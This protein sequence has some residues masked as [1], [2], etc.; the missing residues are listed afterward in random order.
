[1]LYASDSDGG[2]AEIALQQPSKKHKRNDLQD[3]LQRQCTCKARVCFQQ[4][5]LE[6]AEV[7]NARDKFNELE[8]ASKNNFLRRAL[9]LSN[10]SAEG[11]V[12]RVVE[13]SDFAC[14]SDG[15]IYASDEELLSV[16]S[17]NSDHELLYASDDEPRQ[18]N[19]QATRSYASNRQSDMCFLGKPVCRRAYERLLGVGGSTIARLK[20]GEDAFTNCSRPKAAKHP[21]FGFSLDR[22]GKWMGILF[23]FFYL[24]HSAAEHLPTTFHMPN[25]ELPAD[26]K[27]PDRTQRIVNAFLQKLHVYQHDPEV[28]NIGPSTFD[29]PKR[30]VQHTSRT[31]LYYEYV[32][33]IKSRGEDPASY[34]H[35]L[36]V[37]NKVI[38]PHVRNSQ[39]KVRKRLEHGECDDCFR[40]KQAIRQAKTSAAKEHSYRQYSQHIL[41]QWLDRQHYWAAKT[42]SAAF[43][44]TMLSFGERLIRGSLS[45]HNLAM[46][47]DGM[48][49]SKLRSP[50]VFN[51]E[52]K[53][54]KALFRPPLHL[55]VSWIHSFLANMVIS[56]PDLRKDSTT[57]IEIMS[58][59]L[60]ELYS[61]YKC[62]PGGSAGRCR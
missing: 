61:T 3:L 48:D 38:G 19:G 25:Q 57:Q 5:A 30:H 56:D 10:N 11:E 52:S 41:S 24:Y 14:V 22:L 53:L 36:R 4:F 55:T 12:A 17:C 35:F 8:P 2:D 33:Y 20:A 26:T 7:R 23:F 1:M 16:S 59:S 49:Q 13:H 62:L 37:A 43:V 42:K 40:L 29:G 31:D 45:T 28:T 6:T 60:D 21:V 34:V 50:R 27:D 15:L 18:S 51:R 46:I 32:G 58:R 9:N 44:N 39:L 54:F 47:M